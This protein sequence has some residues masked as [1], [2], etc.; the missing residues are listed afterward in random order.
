MK[1][2]TDGW[3]ARIA[4][5]FTFH[6]V[7]RVAQGVADYAAERWDLRRPVVIGYDHRFGSDD[8]A[9][10]VARVLAGNGISCRLTADPAPTPAI[11]YA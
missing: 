7:A 4:A 3:R 1:F 8:F 2:G 11:A 10:C 9:L 5:E 6:N